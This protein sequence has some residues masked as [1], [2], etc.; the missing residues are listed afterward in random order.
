MQEATFEGRLNV[1]PCDEGLPN[2]KFCDDRRLECHYACRPRGTD[3]TDKIS[4]R[5]PALPLSPS[6]PSSNHIS[7]ATNGLQ[8]DSRLLEATLLHHYYT[9]TY[10]T[11]VEDENSRLEWQVNLPK[12]ASTQPFALDSLLAFTALHLAYLEPNRRHFWTL[13][14]FNYSDKAC[15]ML[16]QVTGRLSAATADAAMVCS[17]YIV[18]FVIAQHR[19]SRLSTSYLDEVLRIAKL[20]RGC[21]L[22]FG[23]STLFGQSSEKGADHETA[24]QDLNNR[25]RQVASKIHSLASQILSQLHHLAPH[26]PAHHHRAYIES[27]Q[28]ILENFDASKCPRGRPDMGA[29]LLWPLFFPE[30]FATLLQERDLVARIIFLLYPLSLHSSKDAWF[31]GD[32][33]ETLSGELI[34]P[35]ERIPPEWDET[36]GK[37]RQ[38]FR[39]GHSDSALNV[40]P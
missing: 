12:V 25:N 24:Q 30:T 17:I 6:L 23:K 5:P 2:C 15:S 16:S 32:L 29:I 18:L 22:L 9:N 38:E 26:I 3:P 7:V 40:H 4:P 21:I 20:I 28:Y 10:A 34:S 8:I 19:F 35:E 27:T 14:A 11:L 39:G 37:I 13:V 1:R 31:I 36:L 33:G